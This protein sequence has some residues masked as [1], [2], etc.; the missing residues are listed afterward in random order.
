MQWKKCED[1]LIH[2]NNFS[3]KTVEG[4]LLRCENVHLR[5]TFFYM[6][7]DFKNLHRR[8]NC[9]SVCPQ[10]IQLTFTGPKI[11]AY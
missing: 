4:S 6:K 10:I 3:T 5:F 9:E 7:L 11:Q 2:H 1:A 8:Q